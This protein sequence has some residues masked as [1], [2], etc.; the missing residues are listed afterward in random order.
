V[1]AC[2]VEAARSQGHPLDAE[3]DPEKEP[4]H[5]AV[6]PQLCF[7]WSWAS[8]EDQPSLQR[9]VRRG[10]LAPLSGAFE[11][12]ESAPEVQGGLQEGESPLRS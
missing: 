10:E 8:Q 3:A 9:E 4:L 2:L 1:S 6:P 7:G 5:R 11:E 12:E